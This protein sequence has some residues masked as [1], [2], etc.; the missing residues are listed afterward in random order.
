MSSFLPSQFQEAILNKN[1]N[2]MVIGIVLFISFLL[3]FFFR[4]QISQ[5]KEI[6][7]AKLR[8][9][10]KPMFFKVENGTIYSSEEGTMNFIWNYLDTYF[11]APSEAGETG[12]YDYLPSDDEEVIETVEPF[13]KTNDNNSKEE[14]ED[15]DEE[16]ETDAE[17]DADEQ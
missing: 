16:E 11:L 6:L 17:E 2:N 14:E 9:T 8:S 3:I 1:N 4:D 5:F 10:L 12:I 7:K 15:D 13:S